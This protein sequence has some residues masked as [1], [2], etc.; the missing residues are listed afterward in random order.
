M[1]PL[2]DLVVLDFTHML[3]GPYGTMLLADLGAQTIKI[4]PPGTGE[5]TRKLLATD[6]DHSR[7]GMGAYFLTLARN[8]RS[9]CIDMKSEEGRAVFY[10]LVERADVIVENFSP[11]VARRIGIDYKTVSAINPRIITCS[12]SGFGND[13]PGMNRPAFDMVAQGMGGGM[14]L[15][16]EADGRPLRA[17]IPIGDLGG[18]LMGAIGI[19]SAVHARSVT[20]K[21]QHVDIS[22]LDAQISMLN[23][24]ATMYLLSGRSPGRA[25]NGH[26]VHVPYDT[27]R[28]A[29]RDLII[30]VITD[31]F[32]ASLVELLGDPDLAQEKYAGQPG[33]LADR[34][35]INER[36]QQH[37]LTKPCE[38]WLEKLEARRIPCAPVNELS[39]ALSDEQVR[40]RNMVVSVGLP[41]GTVVDMPGNPVKMSD[42]ASEEF[43]PPPRLGA[44]TDDVLAR[45]GGFSEADIARLRQQGIVA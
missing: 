2:S 20:G 34:A 36:L 17:G 45:L 27:F 37:F 9:V 32:W 14:S 3:S 15:T 19:L 33:R 26:F 11:G 25:G 44:D 38:Y 30:A 16:G 4:E 41:S 31:N 29:S 35:F 13:G 12:I 8:K 23:Y 1:K 28:T 21:G 40:A 43:T 18:G 42:Y 10:R 5:G 24:M 22:M 6:P 7:D 39:H